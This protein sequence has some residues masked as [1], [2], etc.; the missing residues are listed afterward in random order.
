VVKLNLKIKDE[1]PQL[2]ST[3]DE[4]TS[5]KL[6][7]LEMNKKIADM[8][9]KLE[10]KELENHKIEKQTLEIQANLGSMESELTQKQITLMQEE[11]NLKIVRNMKIKVDNLSERLSYLLN[12]SNFTGTM[13]TTTNLFDAQ[14]SSIKI[15]CFLLVRDF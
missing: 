13:N 6:R 15:F 7:Q 2:Y 3:D 9:L 14:T 4:Y 1:I 12:S 10:E 11:N 5:L 8:K